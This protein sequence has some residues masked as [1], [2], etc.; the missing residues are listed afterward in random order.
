[1]SKREREYVYRGKKLTFT[2]SEKPLRKNQEEWSWLD[3]E[4]EDFIKS[5]DLYRDF[6]TDDFTLEELKRLKTGVRG[7]IT[8][9]FKNRGVAVVSRSIFDKDRKKVSMRLQLVKKVKK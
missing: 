4:M 8:G 3:P 6:I 2:R 1:M 7:R 9:K 5:A